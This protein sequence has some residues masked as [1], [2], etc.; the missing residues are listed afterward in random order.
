MNNVTF[1][2]PQFFYLLLN[3]PLLIY[4][5]WKFNNTQRAGVSISSSQSF[6]QYT[7]SLRHRLRHL[8]F[9]FRLLAIAL[10]IVALARPQTSFR[11]QRVTSDG[12]DVVLSIDI[13]G[14]M[15]AED[16]K[17]NRMQA[18]KEVAVDFVSSRPNDRIGLVIFSG[19]GFT[20]SPLTT[21][22][23]VLVNLLSSIKS[24]T[25]AEGTAIG[26]GLATA[27]NRLKDSKSKS[28][29]IILLTDGVNNS[30]AIAP[31]TAA[32][33]AQL[34]NIKVYTIGVGSQ[35]N[36]PYPLQGP[37]GG[38]NY[39]NVPVEID[40]EILQKIADQTGGKYYRATNNRSLRAIYKEIDQL[41]K[42][43]IEVNQFRRHTE[44]FLP[45][46]LLAAIFLLG[47]I[48]LRYTFLRSLP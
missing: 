46:A 38:V 33:M 25:L 12:I 20:Q 13:S 43:K 9:I 44:E 29:V 6:K 17:P 48:A 41:E 36:A 21:D 42:T 19:E 39:Q 14:S 8:P 24:G 2:N 16:L 30:G 40:E 47:D 32:E 26:E 23:D 7:P 31:L 15:L 10:I 37:G 35:G 28:K 34:F 11:I 4:W 27:V 22:H 18:A 5:Y 45:F 1:A 3:L